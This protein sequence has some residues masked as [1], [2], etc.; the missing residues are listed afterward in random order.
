MEL[1]NRRTETTFS[2]AERIKI[3]KA[4]LTFHHHQFF[5]LF[6][7]LQGRNR[8]FWSSRLEK[9]SPAHSE[10]RGDPLHT[11]LK[12][13]SVARWL[14]RSMPLG[15]FS[16]TLLDQCSS[17]SSLLHIWTLPLPA[18]ITWETSS[19][20]YSHIESRR[21]SVASPFSSLW[22]VQCLSGPEGPKIFRR[23]K[24]YRD[25]SVTST[26][27]VPATTTTVLM[28]K[29][30]RP[31]TFSFVSG[32]HASSIPSSLQSLPMVIGPVILAARL[33]KKEVRI[34]Q[35]AS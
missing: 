25:S 32:L 28:H 4:V 24:H 10:S 18:G 19:D 16:P 27:M 3:L 26:L 20:I 15:L 9:L 31:S 35:T 30:I 1:S 7:V 11:K 6:G 2:A 14:F 8:H 34:R 23:L 17:N 12:T 21:I 29:V 13:F 22:C 33:T 5:C